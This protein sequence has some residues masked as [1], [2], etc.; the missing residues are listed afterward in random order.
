MGMP[1]PGASSSPR[2]SAGEKKRAKRREKMSKTRRA[3]VNGPLD[4]SL[5]EMLLAILDRFIFGIESLFNASC[6][7]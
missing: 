4:A 2:K 1:S 3:C 5:F 7:A 6:G